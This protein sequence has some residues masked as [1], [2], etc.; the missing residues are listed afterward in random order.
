MKNQ[1][2]ASNSGVVVIVV[3]DDLAV[4]N[5]LKFWL[6]IEGLTVRSYVSAADLLSAGDLARCDCYVVDQKMSAT[7]ALN[8]IAQLRDQRLTAPAI[9]ITSHPSLSLRQQA[10]KAEVP[11]VE[12]PLVGNA[13]L[14]KI[15]DVVG[16]R[17]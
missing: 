2:K 4:R 7:S 12:K 17:G 13:L 5:S 3:S 9:L 10:E 16:A 6:E 11:I 14:D 1:G 8:L 15:R